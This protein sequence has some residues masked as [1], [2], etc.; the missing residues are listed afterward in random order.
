MDF[1]FQWLTQYGYPVLFGLLMVGIVGLPVPDEL[2]LSFA[3]YLV[4]RGDFHAGPTMAV[5]LAGSC[6]GISLSYVI[7][8]TGG[9]AFVRRFGR[10]LRLNPDRLRRVQRWFE[11]RGRWLLT[12]GYYVPGVRHLT[13]IAAGTFRMRYR[14]FA[15]LGLR[16]G[17]DLVAVVD[18]A[19]HRPGPALAR[20]DQ[21]HPPAP[22]D[23][24]GRRHRAGG[25]VSAGATAG[26][27]T[28][29]R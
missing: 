16:R 4:W 8:R 3:G 25:G 9:H 13:A 15:L 21:G 20:G 14:S 12:F 19:G 6:C 18:L 24:H 29:N 10:Y 7:G 11:R 1:V 26:P 17:A 23:R 28:P 5:A 22:P 2:L 27:Q